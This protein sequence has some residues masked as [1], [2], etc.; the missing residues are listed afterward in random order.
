MVDLAWKIDPDVPAVLGAGTG[1]WGT[2]HCHPVAFGVT[3]IRRYSRMFAD[4]AGLYQSSCNSES[5][6]EGMF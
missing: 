4:T 1:S 5:S 2:Q 3:T 6:K